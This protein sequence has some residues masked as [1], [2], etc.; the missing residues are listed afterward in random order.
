MCV[1]S[2]ARI[3]SILL[4]MLIYKLDLDILQMYLSNKNE[5]SMPSLSKVRAQTVEAN[6]QTD[7]YDQ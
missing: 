1:F 2:Y 7:R 3:S 5:V 4:L 6:T